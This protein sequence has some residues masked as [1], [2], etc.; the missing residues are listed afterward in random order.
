MR[1]DFADRSNGETEVKLEKVGEVSPLLR[2]AKDRAE[3]LQINR[4]RYTWMFFLFFLPL[5]LFA[6]KIELVHNVPIHYWI[7]DAEKALL[8][9]NIEIVQSNLRKDKDRDQVSYFVFWNKP[10]CAKRKRLVK[11][12]KDQ[13]LLFA[14]ESPVFQK[15]LYS[16]KYLRHFKRIYTWDDDLVDNKRFFKLY[17]PELKPM[18]ADFPPFEQKKLCTFMFSNK[19]GKHPKELY[20]EREK[21]VQFFENKPEGDFEFYGQL[22][23][24]AGYK[25]YRGAPESKIDTLKNY[26]FCICYENVHDV[27]GYITEKIFDAFAA[28]CIPIY[29]GASNVTE[30]IPEGCFI[31]R[32]KFK[33]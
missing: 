19:R 20:T 5:L 32:R 7:T 14:W 2:S 26:R 15:K 4:V 31:D 28:G 17:Y 33:D 18:I 30:Y 27:K 21:V 23:E 24:K 8:K 29:W 25:N 22:W 13:A 6:E 12:P 1:R 9:K 11:I 3:T 10:S 16:R